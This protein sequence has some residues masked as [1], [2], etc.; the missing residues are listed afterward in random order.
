MIDITDQNLKRY[1]LDFGSDEFFYEHLSDLGCNKDIAAAFGY[2]C[3]R[4]A[5]DI[6]SNIRKGKVIASRFKV[7]CN[8]LNKK[9]EEILSKYQPKVIQR[10]GNNTRIKGIPRM[11]KAEESVRKA[12]YEAICDGI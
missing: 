5:A 12:V 8:N 1:S 11:K 10:F 4:S 9:P 3:N 7:M 2:S 6:V